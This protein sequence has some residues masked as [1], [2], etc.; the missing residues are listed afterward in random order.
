MLCMKWG[1]YC[2]I[3][4]CIVLF[5]CICPVQ[6]NPVVPSV[7]KIH[8]SQEGK[9]YNESVNFTIN[10][11]GYFQENQGNG[12][13]VKHSPNEKNG[14]GGH[15]LV[16]SRSASCPFYGCPVVVMMSF[17]DFDSKWCNLEG[18]TRGE[19]FFLNNYSTKPLPESTACRFHEKSENSTDFIDLDGKYWPHSCS[20]NFSI[21]S[22]NDRSETIAFPTYS[23][24]PQSPV[25]SLYCSLLQ[26]LGGRCE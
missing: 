25:A 7:W 9:P 3:V 16:F 8:F 21:P 22:P 20:L 19:R 17:Q 23:F 13:I 6:A 2:R 4:L 10:C 18:L 11:Y 12:V 26:F 1:G 5:F 15:G 24:T 14:T